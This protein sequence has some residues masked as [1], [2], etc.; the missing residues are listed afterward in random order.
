MPIYAHAVGHQGGDALPVRASLTRIDALLKEAQGA[1]AA[2]HLRRRLPGRLHGL[3][4]I[5]KSGGAVTNI[6]YADSPGN[7]LAVDDSGIYWA[8]FQ[9]E[10]THVVLVVAR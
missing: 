5:S 6:A 8:Q 3:N 7:V 10:G 1:R 2:C 9:A 4:K